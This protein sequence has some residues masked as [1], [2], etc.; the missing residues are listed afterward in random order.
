MSRPHVL[1][2]LTEREAITDAIYRAILG[3]D[4]NDVAIFNTAFIR[5]EEAFVFDLNGRIFN[6]LE[7]GRKN[8]LAHVGPMDTTHSMSSLS[9]E[10]SPHLPG[11]VVR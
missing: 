11:C 5:N 1:T 4:H 6:G 7:S 8:I 10:P 9:P 3:F 2:G